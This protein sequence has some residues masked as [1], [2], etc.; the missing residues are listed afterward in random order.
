MAISKAEYR[1][2]APWIAMR[3]AVYKGL[4]DTFHHKEIAV[5]LDDT[6]RE[7]FFYAVDD[8]ILGFVEVTLRNIVDGCLSSPVGYVEGIYI[9]PTWR[10]RGAA[11]MLLDAAT[12]WCREKGCSEMATDAELDNIDAQRFHAHMG[13]EETYRIVEYRK[14]LTEQPD[15]NVQMPNDRNRRT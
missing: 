9:R 14:S 3:N 10:G 5:I 15:T 4:D 2:I 13:F 11:G 12:A 1:H 6:D 8:V 7:C